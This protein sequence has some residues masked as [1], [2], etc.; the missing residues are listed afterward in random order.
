MRSYVHNAGVLSGPSVLPVNVVAPYLLTGLIRRPTRLG[1]LTSSMHRS[2]RARL[3]GMDWTGS[4]ETASYP[5]SKLFLT[6]LAVAVARLWPD[7]LTNAVDPGWVPTRMGGPGAP[8][9][10][11]LG[12]RTQEWLAVSDEPDAR[13]TGGYWHH[14]TRFEPHPACRDPRFQDELLGRLARHTGTHLT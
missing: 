2:G 6:A 8:D 14:Q 1:Y 5:D 12:H 10:L 4:H 13:T 3:D 9:D 11:T 7:V